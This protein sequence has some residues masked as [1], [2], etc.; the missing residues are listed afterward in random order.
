MVSLRKAMRRFWVVYIASAILAFLSDGRFL[1]LSVVPFA[2]RTYHW[3]RCYPT[4]GPLSSCLLFLFATT[5]KRMPLLGWSLHNILLN[6][7]F[8]WSTSGSFSGSSALARSEWTVYSQCGEDGVL[9][10]VFQYI[11]PGQRT[12]VEFGVE[13]GM[14]CCTRYLREKHGWTGLLMDGGFK[15]DQ[16]NLQQEFITKENVNQ[17]FRKHKVPKDL[18]LLVIDIDGNDLHVLK[19]LKDYHPR[20]LVVEVNPTFGGGAG[21]IEYDASHVWKWGSNYFGAGLRSFFEH[22]RDRGYELV[23]VNSSGLN[24]FFVKSSEMKHLRRNGIEAI[25]TPEAGHVPGLGPGVHGGWFHD[26]RL[27]RRRV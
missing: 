10:H 4:Q 1:W 23:Y 8:K 13:D 17:L 2:V 12:Y 26:N 11:G 6:T 21:C 20:V 18:D 14:E 22:A 25:L 15:N 16:I 19:M 7:L 27:T 5:V 24:A 9:E 3:L